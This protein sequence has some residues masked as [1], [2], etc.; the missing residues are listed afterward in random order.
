VVAGNFIIVFSFDEF[1]VSRRALRVE[2]SRYAPC[3]VL[4]AAHVT[5]SRRHPYC[6][7]AEGVL[8]QLNARGRQFTAT[9]ENSKAKSALLISSFSRSP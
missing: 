1:S 4:A 5:G 3:T 2:P 9:M 8:Y 7:V 6:F